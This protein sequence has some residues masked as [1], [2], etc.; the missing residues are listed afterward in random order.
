M[1]WK[2][3][4]L[5]SKA[6]IE[7]ALTLSEDETRWDSATP[8]SG[9]ELDE[10]ADQ[11][12]LECWCEHKP[13]AA[14]KQQLAALFDPPAN[15]VTAEKLPDTDWV[16]ESQRGTQPIR[17]G[18]FYVHT[19][20]HPPSTDPALTSFCI[21]A[22]QAF[23][24]GQHET[25][26]GCLALLD[27]MRCVG[28]VA[29]NIIDVGTGTGLLAFAA[30]KLWPR[31]RLTATDIDP[32]CLPA[33]EGN[34]A[35][36]GIAAGK[37]PGQLT[38]VI[39]DGLAHRTLIEREPYD[40]II[41][42]ILAGPLVEMAEEFVDALAPHGSIVLAGLLNTQAADVVTAYRRAGMRLQARMIN[43]DWTILWLR[44]RF[45]G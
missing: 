26:E 20:E 21:P 45:R 6:Q 15:A 5:G 14:L 44:Q 9:Q 18:R 28:L 4:A 43:G 3:S 13:D 35:L 29:R 12:A 8:I 24:T 31:A 32:V 27:A 22:A 16:T 17:S 10:A 19:P 37:A 42:N 38:M 7:A 23:G 30:G 25:T 34:M 2:L 36:N 41:A 1:T 11:W 39:A 33:V 40:L